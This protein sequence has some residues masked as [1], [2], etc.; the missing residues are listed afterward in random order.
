MIAPVGAFLLDSDLCFRSSG[1]RRA[2]ASTTTRS[3]YWQQDQT[4]RVVAKHYVFWRGTVLK[5]GHTLNEREPIMKTINNRLAALAFGIAVAAVASPGLARS[6][7]NNNGYPI[8][9]ARAEALREC[10]ARAQPYLNRD[11]GVRQDAVY[12]ACM[13]EHHQPE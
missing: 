11:W 6:D 8:S 7:N 12:R 10:N 3:R 13:A 5:N 4:N 1:M 2:I 9:G